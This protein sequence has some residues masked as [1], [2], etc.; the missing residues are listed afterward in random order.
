MHGPFSPGS[1]LRASSES[2]LRRAPARVGSSESP[3]YAS[4]AFAGKLRV[5]LRVGL[6]LPDLMAPSLFTMPAV[7]PGPPALRSRKAFPGV[8]R[9]SLRIPLH[10]RKRRYQL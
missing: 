2:A 8:Q 3:A 6:P 7:P 4:P 5:D 9:R 10:E 1:A